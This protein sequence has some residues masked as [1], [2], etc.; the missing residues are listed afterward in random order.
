MEITDPK[1]AEAL[2]KW[3]ATHKGGGIERRYVSEEV[4]LDFDTKQPRITGYAAVF[5]QRTQLWP[6]LYEEV[7]PGAFQNAIGRDDV[8]ALI[9]H[10][11]NMLLG[12]TKAGTLTL[13]EDEHGLRYEIMPPDTSYAKD[14]Q[15]SLK[16]KDINQIVVWIQYRKVF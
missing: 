3:R 13:T 5:N 9:N 4:R 2:D 10:D 14:L 11:P 1:L 8:R 16:R 15:V 7:A 6:G 12:R